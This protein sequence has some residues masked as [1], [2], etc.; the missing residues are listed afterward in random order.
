LAVAF[1]GSCDREPAFTLSLAYAETPKRGG[2]LK[3]V[4]PSEFPS[5]ALIS[6]VIMPRDRRRNDHLHHGRGAD[7][8]LALTSP[9]SDLLYQGMDLKSDTASDAGTF[10][11]SLIG[12]PYSFGFIR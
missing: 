7:P 12:Q 4:V 3:F 1:L 10:S 11:T 9:A 2:I 5:N 6:S 8:R